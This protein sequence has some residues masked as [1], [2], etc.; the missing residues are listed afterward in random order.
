MEILSA[1]S[2]LFG[3]HLRVF[4]IAMFYVTLLIFPSEQN[5]IK[6]SVPENKPSGFV[7]YRFPS[8]TSGEVYQLYDSRYTD[9][10]EPM[11][12]FQISYTGIITTTQPLDYGQD[13]KNNFELTI[14][15]RKRGE[16]SGG[17]AFTIQVQVTDN[18]NFVP[19]FG[20]RTYNGT[21][22]ENSPMNTK[23][24]GIVNCHAEDKDS[25]GI[26]GYKIIDGNEKGYFEVNTV[27]IEDEKFLELKTTSVPIVKTSGNVEKITLIVEAED[28]GKPSLKGAAKIVVTIEPTN[29]NA[30][31]FEKENYKVNISEEI[32]LMSTAVKVHAVDT[33]VGDG[34]SLYYILDPLS[35]YFT[36]NP[37][38]GQIESI[39]TLDYN[40]KNVFE[41]KVVAQDRGKPSK[42]TSTKVTIRIERD[43]M[44][45]PPKDS[46]NPGVNTSPVFP[47]GTLA[48]TVRE[49]LPIGAFVTLIHAIDND[50]PGP[51]KQLV[52][53][54]TG[55][56]SD[57]FKVD[58][59]SGLVTLLNQ[60]D[61]E[62]GPK[63]LNLTV[64]ATDKGSPS[65]ST[66]T[67]LI[68]YVIDVNE[69]LN[70]PVFEPSVRSLSLPEDTPIGKS[71]MTVSATDSD[72]G[73]DGKLV[74]SAVSG[75]GIHYL[76]VD[77][78]TGVM[79]TTA[80]VDREKREHFELVIA[81]QDTGHFPRTSLLYLIV[82][83]QAVDD[84]YPEFSS[85]WYNASVPDGSP[86]DTFVTVLYALDKDGQSLTYTILNPGANDPFKIERDSGVIRTSRI[87]DLNAGDKYFNQLIIQVQGGQTKSQ[88][89]VNIMITSSSNSVPKF[90]TSSYQVSVRENIGKV[91]SLICLAATDSNVRGITY[92][93]TTG[94]SE[95][96]AVQA[97]SGKIG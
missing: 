11:K 7:V 20:F 95:N 68:V 89:I 9:S 88:A 73:V 72:V 83:V 96:F 60:L 47:S 12:L 44:H 10:L 62:T 93:I 86:G 58:P 1:F 32:P 52:Y 84:H 56:N 26:K 39:R 92:S 65:L 35:D 55:T 27:T 81:A 43:L 63:K 28:N 66:T 29:K 53:S 36:V 80:Y 24:R 48:A 61:Y 16:T 18:N 50:P 49:D 2:S 57:S 94:G 67:F 37:I 15:L 90:R 34:G 42:Q 13:G 70:P 78:T 91:D 4:C 19:T 82:K 22:K 54:L 79:T 40:S 45:F 59:Q 21:I 23:V 87:V 46:E 33:D 97:T 31:K 8:P 25:H 41:L 6:V 75:E 69:N 85:S 3:S 14:V 17:K 76:T 38:T 77:K 51:N 64:T 71:V 30:P 5:I 74:Y